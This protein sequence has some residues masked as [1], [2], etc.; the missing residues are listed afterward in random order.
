[1]K[2]SLGT[3]GDQGKVLKKLEE[4][5][6]EANILILRMPGYKSSEVTLSG[7]EFDRTSQSGCDLLVV[8]MTFQEV[9]FSAKRKVITKSGKPVQPED[10]GEKI[11]QKISG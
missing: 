3:A 2:D 8:R 11:P 1:M 7:Y 5:R 4:Q 10:M 6:K 9:R